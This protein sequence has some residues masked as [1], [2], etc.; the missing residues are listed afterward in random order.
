VAARRRACFAKPQFVG[1]NASARRR[2]A[3]KL[4]I[5]A[6]R[7]ILVAVSLLSVSTCCLGCGRPDIGVTTTITAVSVTTTILSGPSRSLSP[8]EAALVGTWEALDKGT[9]WVDQITFE[10]RSDGTFEYFSSK[11]GTGTGKEQMTGRFNIEG[12]HLVLKDVTGTRDDGSNT[13]ELLDTDRTLWYALDGD[14]LSLNGVP[15]D[16]VSK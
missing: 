3:M 14:V 2:A 8:E 15:Y 13:T 11:G 16:R 10:F 9:D 12:E 5:G 1:I 4:G 6:I 7:F